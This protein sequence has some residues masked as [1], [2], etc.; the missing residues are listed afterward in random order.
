MPGLSL[1]RADDPDP[2]RQFGDAADRL[3]FLDDYRSERLYADGST[4]LGWTGY[5]SYPVRTVETEQAIVALE[6]YLYDTDDV[7]RAV[8]E[9]TDALLA[10][11][12]AAVR[13]WLL[14]RDAEFVLVAVERDTGDVIALT[15]VLGRLPTYLCETGEGVAL[16]RE[17]RFVLDTVPV[18]ADSMGI[19]E[20]LLFGYPLGERTLYEGVRQIPPASIVRIADGDASVEQCHRYSFEGTPHADRSLEENA[21]RLAGLLGDACDRR[22]DSGQNLVSLSGGLDSRALAACMTANDLPYDAVT[23]DLDAGDPSEEARIAGEVMDVL[24]GDWRR[25]QVAHPTGEDLQ[26]LLAMKAGMNYLGMGFILR[27]FDQLRDVYGP[28]ATLFTGDGGDKIFPAHGAREFASSEGVIDY[29]LEDAARMDVETVADLTTHGRE[30]IA[31]DLRDRLDAYPTD[32]PNEAYIQFLFRERGAKWLFHGED[33]NRYF[34]WNA[35]PFWSWPLV[36]YAMGVPDAQ[37]RRETLFARTIAEFSPAVVDVDYAN[38]S[39]PITSLEYSVKRFTYDVLS[40]YPSVRDAVVTA[41]RGE[42]GTGYDGTVASVLKRQATGAADV[43]DVLSAG[44]LDDLATDRAACD[45]TAIYNV[46]TVTA[47]L[48]ALDGES[49][50]NEF[51]TATFE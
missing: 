31:A 3:L 13:E 16:S 6:G 33:R 2:A 48:E 37:K 35:A 43:G 41:L 21:T 18:A 12:A 23:Y 42:S 44:T 36:R 7:E 10:S 4:A 20:M 15:D 17:L 26:R 39:A 24:G 14:D 5:A 34:F 19:A 32:D 49:T 1:L 29:V 25:F 27:F 46:L 50:L 8:R 47:G 45:K 38:F 30:D 40:R 22:A 28:D 9:V 11:D 51:A